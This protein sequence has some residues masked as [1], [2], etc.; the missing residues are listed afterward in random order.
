MRKECS[1]P[2]FNPLYFYRHI[3]LFY[4]S[5][6]QIRKQIIDTVCV[7]ANNLLLLISECSMENG[8]ISYLNVKKS[9]RNI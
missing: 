6:H 7:C 9:I 5:I 3:H 8:H 2:S 4:H 1:T